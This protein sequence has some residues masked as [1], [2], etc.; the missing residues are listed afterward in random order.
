[1]MSNKPEVPEEVYAWAS[2]T[3]ETVAAHMVQRKLL[4]GKIRVETRW[5]LPHRIFLGVAW[6]KDNPGRKYWVISGEVPTDHLDAR[7]ARSPRDAARHFAL[8]W[9]LQGARVG[10]AAD[11]EGHKGEVDWKGMEQRLAEHAEFLYSLV[12]RDDP[13]EGTVPAQTGD[14]RND[15]E[16]PD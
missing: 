11:G 8:R 2:A 16:N 13:W 3:S 7:T 15:Q 6:S 5:I 14:E 1:M 9:Q 10:T 4:K 12:T